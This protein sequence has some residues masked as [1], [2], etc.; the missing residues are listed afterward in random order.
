MQGRTL[1]DTGAPRVE[2]WGIG[3][4]LGRW[5][6]Y[7]SCFP[8]SHDSLQLCQRLQ[9]LNLLDLVVIKIQLSKTL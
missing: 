3:L 4:V 6:R 7:P 8:R 1:A 9:I 2:S 5:D